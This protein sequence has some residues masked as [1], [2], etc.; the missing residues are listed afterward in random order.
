[1]GRYEFLLRNSAHVDMLSAVDNKLAWMIKYRY[2]V[3][4]CNID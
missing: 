1:M 3:H 4:A 2:Y